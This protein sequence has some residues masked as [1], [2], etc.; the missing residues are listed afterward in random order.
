MV[1][2]TQPAYLSGEEVA[3]ELAVTNNSSETVYLTPFPPE[4]RI[5]AEDL[6]TVWTSNAGEDRLT[7][8]MGDTVTY[9]LSWDQRDTRGVAVPAGEYRIEFLTYLEQDGQLT[10]ADAEASIIIH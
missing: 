5:A 9:H 1:Q 2:P 10:P 6:G 7:V 4:I 3:V 8:E